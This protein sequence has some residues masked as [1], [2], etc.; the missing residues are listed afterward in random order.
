MD[1]DYFFIKHQEMAIM[2]TCRRS[3][4]F[5]VADESPAAAKNK[6]SRA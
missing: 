4:F 2:L 1:D 3:I 6:K 5:C